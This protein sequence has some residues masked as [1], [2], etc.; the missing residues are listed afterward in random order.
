M[1]K[2]ELGLEILKII[3]NNGYAAYIVGGAVRDHLL[4]LSVEDVDIATSMPIDK[5]STL[6]VVIDT[7]STYLGVTIKYMD[8]LFE[9]TNFRIELNY[10][11]HRHPVVRLVKSLEVDVKRRD[12]TINALAYDY[13]MKLH[14][15][16]NG[17][18]DLNNKIIKSI[19]NPQIK[20]EEDALRML[21]AL[22][23]SSKLGFSLDYTIIDALIFKKA[24]LKELS[25]ERIY[26]YFKKLLYFKDKSGINYINQYDLFSEIPEYKKWLLCVNDTYNEDYLPIYYYLKYNEFPSITTNKIKKLASITK[27]LIEN[28]F[29]TYLLYKYKDEFYL[30]KDVLIS[31]GYDI[32]SIENIINGF[33]IKG[34]SDLEL[35]KQEIAK[36][37]NG[38]NISLAIRLVIEAILEKRI[39]N[40]KEEILEFLKG[41]DFYGR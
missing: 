15:F 11:N 27:E 26:F 34:D 2:L 22:Y 8:S 19:G 12:F 31:L 21:R 39:N 41:F 33:V 23:F 37:F 38:D 1:N 14:D 35:S 18:N 40:K 32:I 16:Y 6:F 3:N 7:G 5:L 9:V 17:V 30:I 4:G 36:L 20:F 29:N 24:L 13:N 10:E 28:N 25:H